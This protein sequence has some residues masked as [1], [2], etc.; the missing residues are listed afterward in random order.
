MRVAVLGGE[1]WT[2]SFRNDMENTFDLKVVDI[3]GQT[4]LMGLGI[5]SEALDEKDGLHFAEDHFYPEIIDPDTGNLVE[6]GQEGELVVTSL[7]KQGVPLIR[8][9]TR[10]LTRLLPP[11]SFSVR[12]IEKPHG[13]SD[14][15][16]VVRGISIYPSQIQEHVKSIKGIAEHFQIALHKEGGMDV[17]LIHVEALED[18][19]DEATRRQV[20]QV[21]ARGI[22]AALDISVAVIVQN[23]GQINREESALRP[24]IDNR[25][26]G[27]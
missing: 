27:G 16:I 21:L 25:R 24:V 13:R 11:T 19:G 8:F 1:P 26:K 20:R 7:T 14:D 12:R 5:A 10:D 3:Y 18:A 15:L 17:M 2:D 22:K 9:R 4:E 23:P 6:D